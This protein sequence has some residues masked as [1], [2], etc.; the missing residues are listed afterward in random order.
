MDDQR[1]EDADIADRCGVGLQVG[2]GDLV[3]EVGE[4]H[5]GDLV[6]PERGAGGGDVAGYVG[7]LLLGLRRLHPEILDNRR[8][9]AS[10][11]QGN[12]HPQTH[13][14]GGQ[15]PSLHPNID[16]QQHHGE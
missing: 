13:G 12:Q 3:V 2:T 4:L 10:H 6:E 8:V 11:H 7:G 14:Q 1:V 5:L 15:H 16:Q 9:D